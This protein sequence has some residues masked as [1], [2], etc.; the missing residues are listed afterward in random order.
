MTLPARKAIESVR[1]HLPECIRQPRYLRALHPLEQ[2]LGNCCSSYYFEWHLS[3]PDRTDLLYSLTRENGQRLHDR[4][5]AN[6]RSTGD[7]RWGALRRFLEQ[8]E[9]L[10][11]HLRGTLPHIWLASDFS[12]DAQ[13]F[14]PPNLHFCLDPKFTERDSI[15]AYRNQLTLRQFTRAIN[16]IADHSI[17][18]LPASAARSLRTF[19]KALETADGEILHLSFMHGRTPPVFKLNCTLP[20]DAVSDVLTKAGRCADSAPITGLIN[21]FARDEER[22]KC[23]LRIDNGVCA[24]FELEL[25]YNTPLLSDPRRTTML[26]SLLRRKLISRSQATAL[27]KWPGTDDIPGNR[28]APLSRIDRWLDIKLIIDDHAQVTAKAYLGFAPVPALRW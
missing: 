16:A 27:R 3:Q 26:T 14:D 11:A 2:I 4:L 9:T 7:V 15:P 8:W 28:I 25:E 19:F 17:T 6:S 1:G 13:K 23:N 22:I 24:R 5:T 20:R 21:D 10:D 18:S 12:P